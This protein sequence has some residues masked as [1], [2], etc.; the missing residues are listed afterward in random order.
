MTAE[1]F[2]KPRLAALVSEADKAGYS[3]DVT[4]ALLISL[5][6]TMN[7]GADPNPPSDQGGVA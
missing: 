4:V 5:L 1:A 7:F 2:L 6:D 3:Q